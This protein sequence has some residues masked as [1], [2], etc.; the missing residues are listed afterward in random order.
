M[1]AET[2]SDAVDKDKKCYWRFFKIIFVKGE[3]FSI[4]QIMQ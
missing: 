1:V 2:V 4:R 3:K